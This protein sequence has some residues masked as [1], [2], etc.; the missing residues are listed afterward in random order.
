MSLYL[1]NE[2]TQEELDLLSDCILDDPRM[3]SIFVTACRVHIAACRLYGKKCELGKLRG[4][5]FAVPKEHRPQTK[6]RAWTEWAAVFILLC[7]STWLCMYAIR[8]PSENFSESDS[9]TAKIQWITD[10][11]YELTIREKPACAPDNSY[12]GI[13][14]ERPKKRFLLIMEPS[15]QKK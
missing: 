10:S 4:V 11:E 2:A 12:Y 13:I 15:R 9:N 6:L 7:T 1:D 14:G 8:G 3:R 5:N